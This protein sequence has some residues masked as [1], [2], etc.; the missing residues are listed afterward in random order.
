MLCVHRTV[1]V[2]HSHS[3]DNLYYPK[4][5]LDLL[6]FVILRDGE[7][8]VVKIESLVFSLVF[9]VFFGHIDSVIVK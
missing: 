9:L 7:H 5:H 8:I 3:I 2:Y 4:S 1:S 6:K